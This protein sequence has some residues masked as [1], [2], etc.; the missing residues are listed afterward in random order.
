MENNIMICG[1]SS[2]LKLFLQTCIIQDRP[3]N[4]DWFQISE[5]TDPMVASLVNSANFADNFNLEMTLHPRWEQLELLVVGT[6]P[7]SF[8]ETEGKEAKRKWVQLVI[9][10]AMANGFK[11][12][13]CFVADND[14]LWVY[15]ALRFSGLPASNIFG[16]G[17]MP[18][19]ETVARLLGTGLAIGSDPIYANVIGTRDDSFIAWSRAQ[20]AGNSLLSVVTQDNS[21]FDQSKLDQ[22]T[23]TYLDEAKLSHDIVTVLCLQRICRAI[24]FNHPILVPLTHEIE[25]AKQKIAISEPVVL[26]KQGVAVMTKLNLSEEETEQFV[27]VK[28]R[29]LAQIDELRNK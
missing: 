25:F 19:S 5:E 3:L 27:A 29:V 17:T 10:Q 2:E 24:F 13:V 11:G 9:N 22:I 18:L 15:S 28:Q 7:R 14:H 16:L 23:A 26:S 12:K 6:P 21:L 20:I 1:E 8:I 4:C